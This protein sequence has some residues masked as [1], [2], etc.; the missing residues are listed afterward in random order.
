M[1]LTDDFTPASLPPL[2][3]FRLFFRT[4]IDLHDLKGGRAVSEIFTNSAFASL[5]REH[6]S[7]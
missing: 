2:G 1:G 6:F 5:P 4:G 3:S 7:L